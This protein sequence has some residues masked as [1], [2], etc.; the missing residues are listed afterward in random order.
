VNGIA[1]STEAKLDT[2]ASKAG[3]QT[4]FLDLAA[5]DLYRGQF[6]TAK[7]INRVSAADRGDNVA[8]TNP[9]IATETARH[10]SRQRLEDSAEAA[11]SGISDQQLRTLIH[12]DLAVK[13]DRFEQ[14]ARERG[15]PPQE[16]TDTYRE[17]SRLFNAGP[18]P[19]LTR[20]DNAR[21]AYGILANAA[22]PTDIRQGMFNSCTVAA[23]ESRIYTRT[24][25]AAA[26]LVTDIATS[27]AFTTAETNTRVRLDNAS[28][29]WVA[30]GGRSHASQIF[31]VTA[32]N[33]HHSTRNTGLRFEQRTPGQA[34][35]TGPTGA[36][37]ERLINRSGV[38]EQ[39]AGLAPDI[40][41]GH[42]DDISA[43]IT[44]VNERTN[45]MLGRGFLIRTRDQ[46]DPNSGLIDAAMPLAEQ[47]G[48]A[49]DRD[50]LKVD[51]PQE[52]RE[53][54]TRMKRDG[55][56]PA[57]IRVHSRQEPFW[58]ESGHGGA[59]GA[60]GSEGMWHAVCVTDVDPAADRV[61]V[62]NQWVNAD[63]LTGRSRLTTSQLFRS[64]FEPGRR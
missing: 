46:N 13:M 20:E 47:A 8:A 12:R 25:S 58:T 38:I 60:G 55:R 59:G 52:L 56:F 11:L 43:Q 53:L 45:L 42:L 17:I 1:A 4:R 9:I 10:E 21:I 39:T 15:L 2:T 26:R 5:G 14:R 30:P 64:M 32:A 18:R 44:G 23:L 33:I 40:T 57:I 36:T 41:L 27:G 7:D 28:L 37:G 29:A 50:G 31:Q 6:S 49:S 48:L 62:D 22:E 19:P 51:S 3:S 34:D 54:L 24:P 35:A 63:H 61:S 16:I